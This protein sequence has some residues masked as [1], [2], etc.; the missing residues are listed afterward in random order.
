MTPR[1]E[2]AKDAGVAVDRGVTVDSRLRT[3]E[4][5]IYAAGDIARWRDA[6]TGERI[7]VE[8]WGVA[9][10]QGQLAAANM[11]GGDL[12]CEIAPFFWTKHFDLAICYVGHA[13]SWDA[14]IIQGDLASHD[15]TVRY[16]KG[17]RVL[18]AATVGRDR[19]SLLMEI[20]FGAR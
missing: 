9:E 6:L 8:R 11:L 17:G 2:L 3:S 13:E 15:A 5:D 14:T 16:R 7:R 4:P 19:E 18:A 20:G 12:A 1:I 10:R